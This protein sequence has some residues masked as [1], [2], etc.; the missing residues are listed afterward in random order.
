MPCDAK[1]SV[2]LTRYSRPLCLNLPCA[3]PVLQSSVGAPSN[4]ARAFVDST[5]CAFCKP[6]VKL[7]DTAVGNVYVGYWCIALLDDAGPLQRDL[8]TVCSR[9]LLSKYE[10]TSRGFCTMFL[11]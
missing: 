5:A 11:A 6:E 2:A 8:T 1:S 4:N 3:H 10:W 9:F 7:V